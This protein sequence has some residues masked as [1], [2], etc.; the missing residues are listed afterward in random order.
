MTDN[1]DIHNNHINQPPPTSNTN[2]SAEGGDVATSKTAPVSMIHG[3]AWMVFAGLCVLAVAIII[4]VFVIQLFPDEHAQNLAQNFTYKVN[5]IEPVRG[6]IISSDGSLLAT[7]VPEYEIRWDAKAGYDKEEYNAKIDSMAL[8]FSKL[9][10]DRSS[11]EYK[12]LFKKAR[13]EGNRQLQQTS[14]SKKVSIHPQRSIQEWI[15]FR[16][17]IYPRSTFRHTCSANHR[18]GAFGK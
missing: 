5:E 4:K 14:G 9:F 1:R 8:C 10:G 15:C 11:S 7:S 13:S 16:S 2:T 6:Q 12:T 3:K 17:E 18:N